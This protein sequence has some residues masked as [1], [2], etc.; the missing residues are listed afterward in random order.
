M[1]VEIPT[2]G[3]RIE[4][5]LRPIDHPVRL[6]S[7]ELGKLGH[8]VHVLPA[9]LKMGLRI[10]ECTPGELAIIESFGI[11]LVPWNRDGLHKSRSAAPGWQGATTENTGR[12]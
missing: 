9:M 4:A 8:V 10:V 1:T 6:L 7:V 2:T 11:T 3:G 5:R 12:I